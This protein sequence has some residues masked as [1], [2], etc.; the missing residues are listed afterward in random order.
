VTL[1]VVLAL[2]ATWWLANRA[3]DALI[4]RELA[5]AQ[6]GVQAFLAARTAAFAAKSVASAQAPQVRER[7]LRSSERADVLEQAEEYRALV[8]AAWVLVTSDHGILVARTDYPAETDIDL[9][10][11]A[12]IGDALSGEQAEGAWLDAERH[13]LFVAVAIPLRASPEAEPQ[14]VLVAAYGIDDTLAQAIKQAT[15]A[16]VAVFAIDTLARPYIVGSTLPRE[17]LSPALAADTTLAD[18][19]ARDTAGVERA[20]T[21]AEERLIGLAS[22]IRSAGGDVFGG[23]IAFRSPDRELG[24]FRALR[25]TMLLAIALAVALTLLSGYV[26]AREI[27]GPV[28]H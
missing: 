9:S 1:V 14:G 23:F 2:G 17:A 15:T 27:R 24:A 7:L 4:R 10:R 18:A 26:L 25:R 11:S 6:R 5:V 20:A 22:P 3:A 16:D 12:L 19:L 28:R 13:K 21:V 8:S